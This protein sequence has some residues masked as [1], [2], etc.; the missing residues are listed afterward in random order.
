MAKIDVSTIEGYE[1]MSAEDKLNAV[2]GLDVPDS[3]ELEK[4][5]SQISNKNSEI[6][7]WKKKHN[8]L[9]D[10]DQRRQLEIEDTINELKKRNE[11]LERSQSV[12]DY[13]AGLLE[14]G[15]APEEA[16]NAAEKLADGNIKGFFENLMNFR[17]SME[18]TI[19]ANLIRQ[20]PKPGDVGGTELIMTKEK[21]NTLTMREKMQFMSDHPDEYEAMKKGE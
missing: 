15:F 16:S 10:E 1:N 18:K 7:E 2:L 6:S 9:L 4:L 3:S 13:K 11:V 20:N 19:K 17:G 12:S 8:A 21:Y 14:A 5:K